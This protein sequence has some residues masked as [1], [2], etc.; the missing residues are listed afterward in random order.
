MTEAELI[1]ITRDL[2][3]KSSGNLEK[4]PVIKD[5]I[6]SPKSDEVPILSKEKLTKSFI[7]E[8]SIQKTGVIPANKVKWSFQEGLT[9]LCFSW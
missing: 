2:V 4:S 6:S 9:I 8:S 1:S 5:E 7:D 3:I